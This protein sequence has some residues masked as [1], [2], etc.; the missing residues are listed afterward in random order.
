LS[1]GSGR[2]A[3]R[4]DQLRGAT[5]GRILARCASFSKQRPQPYCEE[6]SGGVFRP[7]VAKETLSAGPVA[8][9]TGRP[10]YW[11]R[12]PSSRRAADAVVR[13]RAGRGGAV[14][15]FTPRLGVLPQGRI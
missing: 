5:A 7:D 6:G 10:A 2:S 12:P 1:P 8:P 3:A 9:R 15:G 4:V 11:P 14:P 13:G